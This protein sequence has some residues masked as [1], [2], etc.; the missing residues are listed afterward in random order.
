MV[1]IRCIL[2]RIRLA[3]FY[4]KAA[5]AYNMAADADAAE[6]ACNAM[7]KAQKQLKEV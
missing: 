7:L 4:I 5:Y 6:I 2:R 3:A 1:K